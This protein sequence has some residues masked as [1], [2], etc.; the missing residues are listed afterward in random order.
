MVGNG[1][2]EG[3][4]EK[5]GDGEEIFLRTSFNFESSADCSSPFPF[6]MMSMATL[7]RGEREG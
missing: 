4:G 7:Q 1:A 6:T 3:K 2:G 5:G